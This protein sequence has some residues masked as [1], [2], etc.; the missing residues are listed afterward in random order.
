MTPTADCKNL[1][2]AEGTIAVPRWYL[3]N[4]QTLLFVRKKN[5]LNQALPIKYAALLFTEESN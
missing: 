2:Y 1:S 4:K 5:A 3:L